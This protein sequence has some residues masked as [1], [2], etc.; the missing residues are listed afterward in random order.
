MKSGSRDSSRVPPE[1][2]FIVLRLDGQVTGKRSETVILLLSLDILMLSYPLVM[3]YPTCKRV[4]AKS[5]QINP[6]TLKE[7]Q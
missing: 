6:R 7:M 1:H 2:K 5:H 4:N 3:F